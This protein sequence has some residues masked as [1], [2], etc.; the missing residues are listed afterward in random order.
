MPDGYAWP[1][2]FHTRDQFVSVTQGALVVSLGGRSSAKASLVLSAGET[3]TVPAGT[4]YSTVA[5]GVT[6]I[7][8]TAAGPY[9]VTYVNPAQDPLYRPSFPF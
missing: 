2:H 9:D 6:V 3:A 1:P 5:K 4:R 7:A 8:V